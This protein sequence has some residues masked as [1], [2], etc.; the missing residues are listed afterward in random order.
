M[1]R[2]TGAGQP[3]F[4]YL[5]DHGY[6][7]ADEAD[8][9]AFH[10]SEIPY[11]FGTIRGTP[12]QWPV[13]PDTPTEQRLSDAMMA[14]WGSFARDGVPTA[15]GQPDWPAY[16]RTRN[17]MAFEEGPVVRERLM[18]GMFELHE[19]VVCRRRAAGSTPWNFN[20]GVI[21][22]PLPPASPACP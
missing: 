10:A 8:L 14:Y 3:A 6:P 12:P 7:A 20:F 16:G 19:A 11:V 1:R 22:P 4:L 15:P 2:Q 13:V 17:Y 9:H 21:S 18:P 5:F